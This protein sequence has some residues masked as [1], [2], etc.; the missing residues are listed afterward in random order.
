MS[1]SIEVIAAVH[2]I[3]PR[4]DELLTLGADLERGRVNQEDFNDQRAIETAD[5]LALQQEAGID[6]QENGK[7]HWQD[8]LRPIAKATAGFAPDVDNAPVTRWPGE[9]RFYRQ[10]TITDWLRL[11]PKL[12]EAEIGDLGESISLL[13]PSSFAALCNNEFTEVPAES[14]VFQLYSD[15]LHF[16]EKRGVKRITFE[17]YHNTDRSGSDVKQ[18]AGWAKGTQLSLISP[19]GQAALPYSV[20]ANLGVSVETA[21]GRIIAEYPRHSR[22]NLKGREVWRQVIDASVTV[23][24]ETKLTD[25][26]ISDIRDLSPA[27]LVLTHSVDFDG[28]IPLRQAQDKV[29]LLGDITADARERLGA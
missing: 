8:H 5:W 11:D 27:R 3:A 28:Q 6:I 2:G 13:A 4:S 24:Y 25:R 17:D 26:E 7:L 10:P 20:P 23:P 19:G 15:L 14:N 21:Y 9:N 16:F 18:L 12:L 22:P 1:N 29:R